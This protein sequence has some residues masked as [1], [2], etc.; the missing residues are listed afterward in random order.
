MEQ[1]PDVLYDQLLNW[2]Q[3]KSTN[4]LSFPEKEQEGEQNK[5]PESDTTTEFSEDSAREDDFFDL[6]DDPLDWEE[7]DLDIRY[8]F[9]GSAQKSQSLDMGEIPI[10]QKHF[11]TLLKRKFQAEIANNP[12]LFPWE[13]KISDYQ[14]EYSDELSSQSVPSRQLWMPQLT[15]LLSGRLPDDILCVLLDSCTE[16]VSSLRP[17]GAKIV[18]A[19][20]TLFPDR[21][22]SMNEMAQLVL[23][24]AYRSPGATQER[25]ALSSTLANDYNAATPQQ[26]MALSLMVADEIINNLTLTLSPQQLSAERQWQT[27]VGLV[28]LRAEYKPLGATREPREELAPLRVSVRLP[29]GGSLKVQTN[30]ES[31]QAE[32]TYP[33]YLGVELFDWQPGQSYPVEVCLATPERKPLTFSVVCQ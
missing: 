28:A 11:Q 18:R 6:E 13:T 15:T 32:R 2:L 12:P 17:Q 4:P 16:A 30:Q 14:P 26:Q 29:K 10:V 25:Q 3:Q 21:A 23:R 5:E 1:N 24:T 20:S 31:V 8:Q 7:D 9:G 19:V 27:T 33:G 22:Q